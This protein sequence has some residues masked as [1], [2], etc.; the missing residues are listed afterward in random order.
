MGRAVTKVQK[1]R[2]TEVP[3]P[4]PGLSRFLI[5]RLR[6]VHL[7]NPRAET[8]VGLGDLITSHSVTHLLF[9]CDCPQPQRNQAL[10]RTLIEELVAVDHL[11]VL[12]IKTWSVLWH[13]ILNE[14][15]AAR[16]SFGQVRTVPLQNTALRSVPWQKRKTTLLY[17]QRT[18]FRWR[19][20]L[21]SEVSTDQ[22]D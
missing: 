1:A 21:S 18:G 12:E 2:R 22:C 10:V 17:L 16:H 4:L 20:R 11:E 9:E 7:S 6:K 5:H 8:I 19:R 15:Q 3:K 14:R 13:A